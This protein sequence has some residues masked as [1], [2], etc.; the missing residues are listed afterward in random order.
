[1]ATVVDRKTRY[2]SGWAV[3]WIRTQA[4]LQRVVD[5]APKAN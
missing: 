3:V 2:I 5:Q 1:M 4:A